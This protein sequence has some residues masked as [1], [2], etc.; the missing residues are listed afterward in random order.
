MGAIFVDF[1]GTYDTVWKNKLLYKLVTKH[2][3]GNMLWWFG[4]F[5]DQRLLNICYEITQ[6]SFKTLHTGL[7]QGA[8]SSCLL[9]NVHVDDLI[10]SL[11]DENI[12]V[13]MYADELTMWTSNPKSRANET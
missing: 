3:S 9:F 13:L 4:D 7:P 8:V 12:G 5:L 2:T 11:I 6:S 1:K 10:Q